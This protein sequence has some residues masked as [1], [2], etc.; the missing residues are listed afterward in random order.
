MTNT[1]LCY[2][3][4]LYFP[5]VVTFNRAFILGFFLSAALGLLTAVC[6]LVVRAHQEGSRLQRLLQQVRAAAGGARLLHRFVGQSEL[7]LG[8]VGTSVEEIAATRFLL[9][10]LP[11]LA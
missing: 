3:F 6:A 8:I 7:A 11:I 4:R 5:R 10:K 9:G 1:L 2:G